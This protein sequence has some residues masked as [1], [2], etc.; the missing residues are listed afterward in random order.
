[1]QSVGA[2]GGAK[3]IIT[4][5]LLP[6]AN[7]PSPKRRRGGTEKRSHRRPSPSG[8]IRLPLL[9]AGR[10]SSS[11][12]PGSPS[13]ASCPR[14]PEEPGPAP[15]S[16]PWVDGGRAGRGPESHER[17]KKGAMGECVCKQAQG[18]SWAL[19]PPTHTHDTSGPKRG[20][21]A[22]SLA[23]Q[24]VQSS[25]GKVKLTASARENQIKG[26]ERMP[27]VGKAGGRLGFQ[28]DFEFVLLY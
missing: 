6:L 13:L 7:Q 16:A 21:F 24:D 11:T 25:W 15:C 18:R 27:G 26:R 12:Q 22:G 8:L 2:G 3:E 5:L 17:P 14:P 23:R 1:M 19:F 9:R 20:E 4:P 10:L 28:L